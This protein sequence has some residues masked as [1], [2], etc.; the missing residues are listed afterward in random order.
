MG[1]FASLKRA[2]DFEAG[3]ARLARRPTA[4]L[5]E[6]AVIGLLGAGL[7]TG[8]GPILRAT[9]VAFAVDLA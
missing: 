4:P 2:L 1:A 9:R 6:A 7:A 8:A 3:L 5:P